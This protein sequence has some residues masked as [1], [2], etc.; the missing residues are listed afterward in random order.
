MGRLFYD[1]SITIVTTTKSATEIYE[2]I[3]SVI[4]NVNIKIQ[5]KYE[6]HPELC[7]ILGDWAT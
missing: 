4:E 5:L 1:L 3:R 7:S 6:N 2:N